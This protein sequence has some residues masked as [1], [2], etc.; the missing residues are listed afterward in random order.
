MRFGRLLLLLGVL[1]LALP[2]S[3]GPAV[4]DQDEASAVRTA[5]PIKHVVVIY[6]ENVSFDHYF[7]TY[8]HAANPAGEPA[9]HASARTPTVNGLNDT[10][11]K[12]N[13]NL[14]NPQRLSR[15]QAHTCDQGHDYTAEQLAADHG[16]MDRFVQETGANLTVAQCTGQA[17][18]VS[19]NYAVM[20]Y[21]DGNTVTAMWN[22]AQRFSMSDNHFSTGYGPSTPGALNL[23]SG[24]TFGAICGSSTYNA[25]ACATAPPFYSTNSK[26]GVVAPQGPGTVTGDPQPYFDNCTTRGSAQL[27]GENVGDLL[28]AK[29]LTWGWFQGGF[30]NCATTHA[31]TGGTGAPATKD[32]IPHHQPFQYYQSTANPNHLPPSSPANIGK[33]DQANHQYNVDAFWTAAN[34]GRLPAVSFLKAP[35]YQ[36]GH[37]NYSTPLDEQTFLV[38]SIN[39]LQQLPTWKSTAIVI[40]YDDS[41]GWYDHVMA[42]LVHQS[43]TTLDALTGTNQCGADPT[44]V[45]SGQQARCGFGPRLPLLVISP[46]AKRNFVDSSLSDQSSILRFIEDN[47]S[48]GRIG[49]GSADATAGSLAGMFDYARPSTKPLILDPS[50]GQPR[51]SEQADSEQ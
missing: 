17:T 51:D 19:P 4:A 14:S 29:G 11:L 5:S 18:G 8:P 13:P 21:Y 37:A 16:A 43:Q 31:A 1:L 24:N 46:F 48:L 45:P 36:D 28:N 49:A 10:L 6:Q 39:R 42:P 2:A 32:Y 3:S 15:S 38:T 34:A 22:Y 20:D 44:R 30:D 50:T 26:P 12:I 47:W 33:Q 27:G 41:D 40:A 23:I 7:A 9:F 25:P 35:A